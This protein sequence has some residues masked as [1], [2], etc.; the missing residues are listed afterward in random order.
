MTDLHGG[1]P[2]DLWEIDRPVLV[3]GGPYSN[4]RVT[5]A[6]IKAARSHG[7][8][9]SHVIC[10]GDV[11]A[12]CGEPERTSQLLMQF[13]CHTVF[14]NCE[15]SLGYRLDDCSCG[16]EEGT[17]CDV[18]AGH[19][20]AHADATLSDTS[21]AWMRQ[22]HRRITFTM[23]D[24]RI[25]V[26]HASLNSLNEFVFASTAMDAGFGDYDGIIGGHSGLPFTITSEERFWHNAGATGMPANDGTSRVWYSILNPVDGAIDIRHFA[27]NYDQA[28]AADAMR[29]A[30][31]P[32][33]YAKGLETGLWLG[34]D[35]L[36][37]FERD[38]AGQALTPPDI[39]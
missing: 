32:M 1:A 2:L 35:V 34:L 20:Y 28:A 39:V 17:A 3:F 13:G 10:T 12:Y 22:A 15:D 37:R 16:F 11:A 21:R 33:G 26:V 6:L 7:I 9:P 29:R 19:W 25:A 5:E 23:A 38:Q 27:L 4:A 30:G 24:A 8:A 14:G 31:L 36:P 18:L